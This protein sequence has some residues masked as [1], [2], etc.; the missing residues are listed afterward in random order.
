MPRPTEPGS[1]F[2]HLKCRT[3]AGWIGETHMLHIQ[4]GTRLGNWATQLSEAELKKVTAATRRD[5]AATVWDR[6]VDWFCG[7]KRTEAKKLYFDACN[8]PV[9]AQRAS[10]FLALREL[11]GEGYRGNFRITQNDTATQYVID[12]PV[13]HADGPYLSLT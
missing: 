5:E 8:I 3:I 2:R 1:V 12:R 11:A 7:T 9:A 6:I 4:Q 10:S 13:A